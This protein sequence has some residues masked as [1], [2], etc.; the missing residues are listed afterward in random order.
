EHTVHRYALTFYGRPAAELLVSLTA[1]FTE[2]RRLLERRRAV[3]VPTRLMRVVAQFAGL[4][5]A[6]LVRLDDQ[7]AARN[8]ARTAKTVAHEAGDSKLHAWV[9]SQEAYS[10]YYG[11]D[12]VEAAY[13]AA[14]AQHVARQAA[15]PG[16]AATAALEARIHAL[17]GRSKETH[18]ALRRA[19][20]ALA[21]LDAEARIASPCGY[22]EAK[23]AHHM[24]NA[25]TQLGR[26]AEAA[27][28]QERALALHP[29]SDY[30]NRSLI[31]LDQADR[32]VR[33]DDP[34][35]AAERAAQALRTAD[36]VQRNP[37]VKL[38]AR[39]VL[40]RIPANAAALPAAQEL[41]DLLHD[42]ATH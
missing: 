16:V 4:M 9:L 5:C 7:V 21:G 1:D 10:L 34:P 36:A 11:G 39:Q 24:G 26:T 6:T 28:A 14:Q 20:R 42:A 41:R 30:H 37:V 25:F 27:A 38:R 33:D 2:L 35:A 19:G 18:D 32:L 40:D 29:K 22:N 13:V 3:L 23:F 8:W 15:C 31:M 12:L 17:Y